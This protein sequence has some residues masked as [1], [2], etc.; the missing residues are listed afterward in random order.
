M[1]KI[2]KF[3]RKYSFLVGI[4][5]FFLIIS[6]SNI[7]EIVY[8]IKNIYPPYLILALLVFFPLEFSKTLCWN[9]IL[10]QQGI[11]YSLK[12][13]FLMYCS[14]MYVGIITPG[15]IGEV[16][17]AVYL[18]KDGHSIGKSLI[19]IILDRISDFVFLLLLIFLG[20]LFLA[21]IFKEQILVFIAGIAVAVL[22]FILSVKAGLI[23]NVSKKIFYILIPE[24]YQKIWQINFQDFMAG[25]KV[26]KLRHYFIIF[27]ITA[28]SWVFYYLQM[29]ILAKGI[30]MHVPFSYLMFSVTIA[31]FISLIPIS[32]SG[33]G[34][35]DAALILLFAPFFILKEQVIVFSTLILLM[36]VFAAFVGLICWFIKPLKF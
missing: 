35:R 4:A 36:F 1:K 9:Y 26:F 18:Q 27:F 5:L 22:L 15:K 24:K 19:S 21:T 17:K 30:N 32:V 11:R 3:L 20:S 7:G 31:G 10:K 6:K 16:A 29:Y 23:K 13:S 33:I 2:L 34:T 8:N 25:F 28:F 12:D 14:G